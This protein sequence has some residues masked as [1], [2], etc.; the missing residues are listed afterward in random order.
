MALASVSKNT[1]ASN[2]NIAE[3]RITMQRAFILED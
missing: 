1:A 3:S 2:G